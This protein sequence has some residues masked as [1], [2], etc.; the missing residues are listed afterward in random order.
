MTD[1]RDPVTAYLSLHIGLI[2]EAESDIGVRL[3][4]R[5]AESYLQALYDLQRI[6]PET[7]SRLRDEIHQLK[8]A[9]IAELEARAAEL[10]HSIRAIEEEM[11]SERS[12]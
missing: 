1:T 4:T 11:R 5:G 8:A 12:D 6:R 9:R 10:D 2:T 3:S 7:F